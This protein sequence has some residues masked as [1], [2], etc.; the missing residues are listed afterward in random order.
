MDGANEPAMPSNT[1][2]RILLLFALLAPGP[3]AGAQRSRPDTV[4]A[5]RE[6]VALFQRGDLKRAGIAL[7]LTAAVMPLDRELARRF[8]DSTGLGSPR[9]EGAAGTLTAVHERSML[10]LSLATYLAGR[11]VGARPMADVGLHTAEAVAVGTVVGSFLK[12]TAGRARPRAAGGDPFDFRFAQGY[13][14]GDYRAFPS[15][16]QIGT[17]AAA[18]AITSEMHRLDSRAGR[19]A[20]IVTYGTAGAV[21]LARMY[22]AEHWGSD[23]LLGAAIGIG[24]GKRIVSHAHGNPTNRLDRFLLGTSV[25]PDGMRFTVYERGF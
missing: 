4:A 15:L 2:G 16:H 8:A 12:S 11:L 14:S 5:P 21:G 10:G 6:R 18:A 25:T 17:F 9:F 1:L 22:S 20:G 7:A 24:L 3:V 23:V 19:I 13:T